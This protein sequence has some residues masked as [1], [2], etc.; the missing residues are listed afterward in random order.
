MKT[1]TLFVKKPT[2]NYQKI[3]REDI[4]IIARKDEV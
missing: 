3:K 2:I 1:S 4:N